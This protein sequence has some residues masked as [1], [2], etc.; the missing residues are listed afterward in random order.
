MADDFAFP[1]TTVP[2]AS[3]PVNFPSTEPQPVFSDLGTNRIAASAAIAENTL[4]NGNSDTAAS[5]GNNV[6]AVKSGNTQG[7][8]D[9]IGQLEKSNATDALQGAFVQAAQDPNATPSDLKGITDI[10]KDH[11]QIKP[12]ATEF[13]ALD[14]MRTD[15]G[16]AKTSDVLDK[17]QALIA[18]G[19]L[20]QQRA[21]AYA[22]ANDTSISGIMQRVANAKSGIESQWIPQT[23]LGTANGL[24]ELVNQGHTTAVKALAAATGTP[25]DPKSTGNIVPEISN[26][27]PYGKQVSHLSA[28]AIAMI[29]VTK[30]LQVAGIGAVAA[31]G[32]SLSTKAAAATVN[33]LRNVAGGVIAG[34]VFDPVDDSLN[35]L[36]TN[37]PQ[38]PFAQYFSEP[39]SSYSDQK[40]RQA[41]GDAGLFAGME[42]TLG[43]LTGA[44]KWFYN[45]RGSL[46]TASRVADNPISTT[47]AMGNTPAAAQM[48]TDLISDNPNMNPLVLKTVTQDNALEAVTP[49]ILKTDKDVQLPV[50][51]T[52]NIDALSNQ[53][54]YIAKI[55]DLQS[56][57]YQVARLSPVEQAA[58]NQSMKESLM[59]VYGDKIIQD[60]SVAGI[61]NSEEAGITMANVHLANKDGTSF[62]NSTEAD[63]AAERMG[64]QPGDYSLTDAPNGTVYITRQHPVTEAGFVQPIPLSQVSRIYANPI[65]RRMLNTFNY[66]PPEV[67]GE[68]AVAKFAAKPIND[69]LVKPIIKRYTGVNKNDFETVNQIL[70][71]GRDSLREDGSTG[72]WFSDDEFSTMYRQMRGKEP[73]AKAIDSYK[74]YKEGEDLN[75]LF[76]NNNEYI[77]KARMGMQEFKSTREDFTHS[78]N[79]I[80]QSDL[81][82]IN[83]Y[84]VYDPESDTVLSPSNPLNAQELEKYKD[85]RII[86]LEGSTKVND[87]DAVKYIAMKQGDYSMTPLDRFQVRYREGGRVVYP[88]ARGGYFS[89]QAVTNEMADGSKVYLNPLTHYTSESRQELIEHT[90]KLENARLAYKASVDGD[91]W[92]EVSGVKQDGTFSYRDKEDQ[93]TSEAANDVIS[94]T[95]IRDV[96]DFGDRVAAGNISKDNAFEI[97]RDRELP[98]AYNNKSVTSYADSDHSGTTS[99]LTTNGQTKFRARGDRLLNPQEEVSQVL[100]PQESLERSLN[101]VINAGKTQDYILR[102]QD[103][104]SATAKAYGLLKPEFANSSP[105]AIFT[106][107]EKALQPRVL[108]SKSGISDK[109]YQ[110]LLGLHQS[111]RNTLGFKNGASVAYEETLERYAE[112]CDKQGVNPLSHLP[113]SDGQP[114]KVA[115]LAST[116]PLRAAN[117]FLHFSNFG[118][119]N[120]SHFMIRGVGGVLNTIGL[121]PIRG[122]QAGQA[123]SLYASYLFKEE[124]GLAMSKL[125]GVTKLMGFK[126]PEEFE[127]SARLMVK[128]GAVDIDGS[129][130]DFGKQAAVSLKNG[131]TSMLLHSASASSDVAIRTGEALNQMTAWHVAFMN[132]RDEYPN[133]NID[134]SQ[135]AAYALQQQ[136]KIIFN[137]RGV[138][139][140]NINNV[141]AFNTLLKYKNFM[142]NGL[143]AMTT[144]PLLSVRQKAAYGAGMTGMFGVGGYSALNG[145]L[146]SAGVDEENNPGITKAWKDGILSAMLYDATDHGLDIDLRGLVSPIQNLQDYYLQIATSDSKIWPIVGGPLEAKIEQAGDH[147]GK[148][149]HI[150]EAMNQ[151][152]TD[153]QA[154]DKFQMTEEAAREIGLSVSTWKN[155]EKGMTAYTTQK[156]YDRTGQAIVDGIPQATAI[157]MMT[158]LKANEEST[159]WR[160]TAPTVQQAYQSVKDRS[161]EITGILGQ[162][163][164]LDVNE[165]GDKARIDALTNVARFLQLATPDVDPTLVNREVKGAVRKQGTTSAQKAAKVQALIRANQ[166]NEQQGIQ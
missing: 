24:P 21:D 48:A 60:V 139:A 127:A 165:P 20:I 120:T 131:T 64:M 97:R 94:K 102:V 17:G 95:A 18:S 142:F 50:G 71:V 39:A 82:A 56:S 140:R 14:G 16:Q 34:Q 156:I 128:S 32:A 93:I 23:I 81:S 12:D 155:Y 52:G 57:Y 59:G 67:S 62:A 49:T 22:K 144:S 164:N 130:I 75:Y 1:D 153:S 119:F 149:L 58:A 125:P 38:L 69:S 118:F 92:Q 162:I 9:Y 85:H 73:S 83:K 96:N 110:A 51:I 132:A 65:G 90:T 91:P 66:V 40:F 134:S 135:F 138:L 124:A 159:Y 111:I 26:L 157:A 80:E 6:D 147:V 42:A 116:N 123:A 31:E 86:Q 154:L 129:H 107:G 133:L 47:A 63:N 100:S 5:F 2:A 84:H 8:K 115:D 137:M 88:G 70:A 143:E 122:L 121:Q 104:F 79:A 78:S 19:S 55:N 150:L 72:R 28:F 166:D 15:N 126:N 112:W 74:A 136:E 163:Q 99:Y 146:Q 13:N 27:T 76:S 53:Q 3:P 33:G 109:E 43:G 61:T 105:A 11:Q 37:Y 117:S 29:P 108:I 77:K 160:D 114:R 113:L 41:I 161:N 148:A 30:A 145:M 152:A 158:G 103:Q 87:T 106:A 151:G 44:A 101:S 36:A 45:A 54:A 7:L 89:K 25:L 4:K 141:P 98:S 35:T 10:A 68:A 46:G